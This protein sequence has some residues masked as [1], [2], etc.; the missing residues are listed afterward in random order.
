MSLPPLDGSIVFIY[1]KDF[2]ASCRFYR[3]VLGLERS[4]ELGSDVQI[5]MLAG[6]YLAVVK[7]GVSA[8]ATPPRCAAEA[9]DT[10]I[11]GLL[12]KSTQDVDAYHAR[13]QGAGLGSV[14]SAPQRNDT[15]G[16]YNMMAR[17]PNGY[18]VEVQCFLKPDMLKPLKSKL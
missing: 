7:Q 12:C 14:L 13:I 11:V 5:F 8:S 15:F 9:G 18:L 10:A 4:G 3:E 17:D 2:E 1:A 6:C 16:L